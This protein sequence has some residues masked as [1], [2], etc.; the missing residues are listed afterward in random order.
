MIT[1]NTI[2]V[3]HILCQTAGCTMKVIW[4][5]KSHIFNFFDLSP[6]E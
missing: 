4:F 6:Y 5:K 2:F 3:P 1:S